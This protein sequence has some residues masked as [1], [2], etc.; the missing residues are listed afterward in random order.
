[1]IDIGERV[2]GF[3]LSCYR[4]SLEVRIGNISCKF[5]SGFGGG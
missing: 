1:M 3:R 2:L 4:L 5:A